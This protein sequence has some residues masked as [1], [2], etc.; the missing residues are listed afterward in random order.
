MLLCHQRQEICDTS[1]QYILDDQSI[2]IGVMC[3]YVPGGGFRD[4]VATR[5]AS[6]TIFWSTGRPKIW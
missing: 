3:A 2:R 1:S 4:W 6:P 5:D